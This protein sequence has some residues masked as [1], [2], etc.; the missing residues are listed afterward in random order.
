VTAELLDLRAAL[1]GAHPDSIY[2]AYLSVR[3]LA[4]REPDRGCTNVLDAIIDVLDSAY[5]E[6]ERTA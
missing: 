6:L 2:S 1:T 4:A 3:Q 5:A